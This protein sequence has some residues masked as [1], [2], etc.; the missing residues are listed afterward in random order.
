MTVTY[1]SLHTDVLG[2]SRIEEKTI[3]ILVHSALCTR[4]VSSSTLAKHVI[5]FHCV[6]ISVGLDCF[7]F[8][9]SFF[10]VLTLGTLFLFSLRVTHFDMFFEFRFCF[11]HVVFATRFLSVC[12]AFFLFLCTRTNFQVHHS[13]SSTFL[14]RQISFLL[15]FAKNKSS[16]Q[17]VC[18]S[19]ART[20]TGTRTM[21]PDTN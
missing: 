15:T 5:T 20:H 12:V 6:P 13:L 2:P 1:F 16:E 9:V 14:L 21:L 18:R 3:L 7:C 10:F 17:R 19:S 8:C 11:G 4:F